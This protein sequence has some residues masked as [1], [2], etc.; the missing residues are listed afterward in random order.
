MAKKIEKGIITFSYP[1]DSLFND[2]RLLSAYMTK[3]LAT[4]SGSLLDEF[5]ITEDEE[6]IYNECL[7]N[8]VPNI[9]EVVMGLVT[10]IEDAISYDNG[11]SISLRDNHAYNVNVL[12]LID[13]TLNNCLKYG[14]LA[15]Y[16]SICVNADLYSIAK[17]KLDTNLSQ[18][19]QRLFQLKKKSVSSQL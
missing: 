13:S 10:C 17:N 3:N 6:E 2:V 9:Y 5:C 11:V 15:E 4:E 19:K 18:L 7:K 1:N 14:V 8:T 12:T 16:Y